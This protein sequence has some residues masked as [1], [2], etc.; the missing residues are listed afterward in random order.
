MSSTNKFS[1]IKLS[2]TFLLLL[3]W[4]CFGDLD[5]LLQVVCS[6]LA[7]ANFSVMM[8]VVLPLRTT[9][10][11]LPDFGEE[12]TRLERPTVLRRREQSHLKIV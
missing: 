10:K 6:L 5:T 9:P 8:Y 12:V 2:T 11:A 1:V 7:I 3:L 4:A